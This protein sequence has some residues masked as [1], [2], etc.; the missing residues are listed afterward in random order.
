MAVDV[1][2]SIRI[3]MTLRRRIDEVNL[4]PS[5]V[6]FVCMPLMFPLMLGNNPLSVQESRN[7][8]LLDADRRGGGGTPVPA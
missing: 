1:A 3:A 7:A 6:P 2:A 4:A 5:R 8:T